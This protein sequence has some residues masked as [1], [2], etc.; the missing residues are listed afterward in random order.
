M[1]W[2]ILASEKIL[3]QLS[4][5][6]S[7]GKGRPSKFDNASSREEESGAGECLKAKHPKSKDGSRRRPTYEK[8]GAK[9][10]VDLRYFLCDGMGNIMR[11]SPRKKKGL[12]LGLGRSNFPVEGANVVSKEG[13]DEFH[14]HK[15]ACKWE[16]GLRFG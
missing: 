5:V 12:I 9:K 2:A 4:N 7:V 13:F 11:N 10:N 8:S 15:T 6:D 1:A 3:E 16:Y 14:V